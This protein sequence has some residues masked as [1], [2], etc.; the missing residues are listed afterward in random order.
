MK[1]VQLIRPLFITAIGLH[2]A[3]LLVPIG[4]DE[5]AVIEEIELSELSTNTAQER[6]EK[7]AS[8]SPGALPVPDPNATTVIPAAGTVKPP[9][10]IRSAPQPRTAATPRTA[11]TSTSRRPASREASR[12]TAGRTGTNQAGSSAATPSTTTASASTSSDSASSPSESNARNGSS[13]SASSSTTRT[14]IAPSEDTFTDNATERSASDDSNSNMQ[15]FSGRASSAQTSNTQTVE[16]E[17]P[18]T[19]AALLAKVTQELP[20]DFRLFVANLNQSLTYS[21][22]NTD[23]E[24]AD[25]NRANWQSTIQSQANVGQIEQIAT[26]ASDLTQIDYP[27]ESSL[28][29]E[30]IELSRCLDPWPQ[31]AEIGVL[32][33]SRG[34]VVGE[35]ELIRSTG[36]SALNDE[37]KATVAAYEDFPGD[38]NSKAYTFEVEVNY[39]A[40]TCVSLSELR[41]N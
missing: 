37:I 1:L 2:A 31:P 10:V 9:T 5:S 17:E 4:P 28:E 24:S 35:P 16:V 21:A 13:S 8:T 6:I 32:F 11:T 36:Y 33:D 23:D 18:I 40:D 19:V 7:S 34:E 14:F 25:A 26:T 39:D 38:R 15:A 12:A 30:G 20:D 41:E 27:V 22:K 29:A 3:L